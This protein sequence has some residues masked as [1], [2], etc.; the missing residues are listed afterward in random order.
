MEKQDERAV[1]RGMGMEDICVGICDD[2]EDIHERVKECIGKH[3]KENISFVDF[4]DGEEVLEDQSRMD[5]L[6]LDIEMPKIDGI[7]AGRQLRRRGF[8]GKIIL[9]TNVKERAAEGYEIEVYRYL[10]KPIDEERLVKIMQEVINCFTGMDMVE[11]SAEG[12][13]YQI[14]QRKISY[15]ARLSHSSQTEIIVGKS[16]FRSKMSISEWMGLLD[17]RIFCQT[18]RAYIINLQMAESVGEK[19]V[20]LIS[21]EKIPVSRREKTSVKRR[22]MEYYADLR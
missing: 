10:P 2:F 7:E 20:F 8:Q 14:Q 4:M 9:L 11:L 3:F 5:V 1:K 13:N 15:I 21:G 16:I 12:E 6:F 19:E 18:H 22:F 17:E